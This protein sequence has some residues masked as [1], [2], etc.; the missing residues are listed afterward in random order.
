M[1]CMGDGSVRAMKDSID[2]LTLKSI[3]GASDGNIANLD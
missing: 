2:P 1:A 3:C